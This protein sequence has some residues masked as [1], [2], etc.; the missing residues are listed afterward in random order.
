MKRKI[1]EENDSVVVPCRDDLKLLKIL[2]PVNKIVLHFPR[3][4]ETISEDF[5]FV[6]IIMKN[7]FQPV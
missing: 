7:N 5:T 1:L 2:K 4:C 6:Y 3:L